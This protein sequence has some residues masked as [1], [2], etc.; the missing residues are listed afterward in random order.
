M[1]VLVTG[2]AGQLGSDVVLAA[3]SAGVEVVGFDR[4]GL[5]V[6]DVESVSRALRSEA[7][8]VVINTAAF[9]AVDRCESEREAAFEVNE[10]GVRRVAEACDEVGAHLI[11]ISTDYVFDGT[12]DR[13]YREDDSVGPASVYGASK[14]AGERAALDVL[15]D[16][17][18]IVRTSWVCGEHGGNIVKTALRLAAAGTSLAFVDDQIGHPTFTADLAPA[19]L[20]L[21]ADVAEDSGAGGIVHLTNS[22]IVSWY[23]F[24][25]EVLIAAGH[26]PTSV[27]AISTD[28]LDPPR[29]APRPA[30]S[31]LD[32]T[33]WRARGYEPLRDFRAPLAELVARLDQR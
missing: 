8:D 16:R 3:D 21:A 27:S 18:T 12:L 28:E 22:G 13:P 15:G 4:S 7:P 20:T 32:N 5:D 33:V 1:K 25:R 23:V 19:L 17:A 11:H 10:R 31:V 26:D 29:P 14:L 24:V 6:A 9:T 2:A 30:N